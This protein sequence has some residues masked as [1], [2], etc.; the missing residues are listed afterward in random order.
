MF[1]SPYGQADFSSSLKLSRI[2]GDLPSDPELTFSVQ[3]VFNAKQRSYIQNVN[4]AH[5]YYFRGQ[6]FIFGVH[7]SF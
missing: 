3:N 2:L 5:S 6:T 7:G 1:S 4:E